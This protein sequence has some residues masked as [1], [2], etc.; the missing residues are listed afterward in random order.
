[1]DLG[2]LLTYLYFDTYV[3]IKCNGDVIAEGH[4]VDLADNMLNAGMWGCY[5]IIDISFGRK[6]L[7]INVAEGEY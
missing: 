7:I 4:A 1:M 3:I 2:K 5:D 6:G